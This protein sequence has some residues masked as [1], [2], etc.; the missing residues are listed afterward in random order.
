MFPCLHKLSRITSENWPLTD[1]VEEE[2]EA[3]YTEEE[4]CAP[5][6][7]RSPAAITMKLKETCLLPHSFLSLH[8]KPSFWYI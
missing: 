5:Q 6:V 2:K 7:K 1:W 4:I 3:E 8:K